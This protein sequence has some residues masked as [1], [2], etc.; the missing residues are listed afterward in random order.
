MSYARIGVQ[1]EGS[2]RVDERRVGV[3]EKDLREEVAA[4]ERRDAV[5]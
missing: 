3:S 5:L 2:E 4:E 1:K